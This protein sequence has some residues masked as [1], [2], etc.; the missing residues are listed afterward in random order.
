MA[1]DQKEEEKEQLPTI[2]GDFATWSQ[3]QLVLYF[4]SLNDPQQ[5]LYKK[6]DLESVPVEQLRAWATKAYKIWNAYQLQ[7]KIPSQQQWIPAKEG[8]VPMPLGQEVTSVLKERAKLTRMEQLLAQEEEKQ[9][10]QNQ[11]N[12]VRFQ[13]EVDVNVQLN[14]NGNN[15]VPNNQPPH[16]QQQQKR[17][18]K[19][20]L[21]DCYLA[22]PDDE[23]YEEVQPEEAARFVNGGFAAIKEDVDVLMG[24]QFFKVKNGNGQV[25]Y[26]KR[27]KNGND[28]IKKLRQKRRPTG[29]DSDDE[30]EDEGFQDQLN[31]DPFF[32]R[33]HFFGEPP[34]KKPKVSIGHMVRKFSLYYFIFILVIFIFVCACISEIILPAVAGK[35]SI[36]G[37]S[38]RK[39]NNFG[40]SLRKQMRASVDTHTSFITIEKVPDEPYA[41]QPDVVKQVSLDLVKI[42]AT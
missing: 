8:Q 42:E 26:M 4:I 5:P 20:S 13:E 31:R 24:I 35:G 38:L 37:V 29:F 2:T 19:R 15:Q 22:M 1:H 17:G 10:H 16:Q 18:I 21:E 39:H 11:N 41:K 23:K 9:K 25:F 33:R 30:I 7:G 12:N 27:D 6:D 34:K 32:R 3:A 40:V 28:R 14:G 36:F